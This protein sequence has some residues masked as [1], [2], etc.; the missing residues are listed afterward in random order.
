GT[1]N[2]S[3]VF[4]GQHGLKV[5]RFYLFDGLGCMLAATGFA[6]LGYAVG[7]G[8]DVLVGSV[9]KIERLLAVAVV[10]GAILVWGISRVTRKGLGEWP[11]CCF[12][13]L[14]DAK[15]WA[16]PWPTSSAI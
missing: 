1:R 14:G 7:T 15:L 12:R 4:W 5:T 6:L 2:A 3:M 8:T 9:R 11:V 13:P 10:L 16:W